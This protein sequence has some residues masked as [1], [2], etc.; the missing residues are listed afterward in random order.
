VILRTFGPVANEPKIAPMQRGREGGRAGGRKSG[1][2]G[3]K[4]RGMDGWREGG[5]EKGRGREGERLESR[6][7]LTWYD[8]ARAK[9]H[10]DQTRHTSYL[11]M[12]INACIQSHQA[13]LLP[14]YLRSTAILALL[15]LSIEKL[16]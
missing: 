4:E 1:R 16:C 14:D 6:T 12:H 9:M 13:Y 2:E 15:S 5:R 10:I 7:G 8:H 11:Y 3:G